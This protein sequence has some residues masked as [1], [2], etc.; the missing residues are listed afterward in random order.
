MDP[1][2]CVPMD[3]Q[4]H[5]VKR[6]TTIQV[7]TQVSVNILLGRKYWI[8][9]ALSRVGA[10]TALMVLPAIVIIKLVTVLIHTTGITAS[11]DQTLATVSMEEYVMPAPT[12]LVPVLTTSMEHFVKMKYAT[13]SVHKIHTA[14]MVP[15]NVTQVLREKTALNTIYPMSWQ[16]CGRVFIQMT[17]NYSVVTVLVTVLHSWRNTIHTFTISQQRNVHQKLPIASA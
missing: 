14:P 13:H 2:V 16:I 6:W 9:T 12:T 1:I 7:M 15:V 4:G 10:T 8:V 5:I 3:T 17:H 11:L